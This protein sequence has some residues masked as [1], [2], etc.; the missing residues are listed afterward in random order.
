MYKRMFSTANVLASSIG[1]LLALGSAASCDWLWDQIKW[2]CDQRIEK[3]IPS[4]DGKYV[5]TI[6]WREGGQLSKRFFQELVS[7]NPSEQRLEIQK[8]SLGSA[9]PLSVF[10]WMHD[11]PGTQL[12]V[13]WREPRTLVI[14]YA[15]SRGFEL[16]QRGVSPDGKVSI[17]YVQCHL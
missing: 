9:H 4:P 6:W 3:T 11:D 16:S 10:D 14:Q 17:E 8:H 7:I 2:E 5:A 15:Y 13:H 1:C 12:E